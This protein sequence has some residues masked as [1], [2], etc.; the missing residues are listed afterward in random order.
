MRLQRAPAS[1]GW[2]PYAGGPATDGTRSPATAMLGDAFNNY[3]G[4][5]PIT[6]WSGTRWAA[7]FTGNLI[8]RTAGQYS[9]IL[10]MEGL[11][12]VGGGATRVSGPM[13]G[14]PALTAFSSLP[15]MG[16]KNGLIRNPTHS[17]K[18]P[19]QLPIRRS[20]PLRA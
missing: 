8:I 3:I 17:A 7:V 5:V 11:M 1:P 19:H 9:L 18:R 13:D 4:N 15:A 2:Q 14:A 20:V 6:G 12:I 16:A 10:D